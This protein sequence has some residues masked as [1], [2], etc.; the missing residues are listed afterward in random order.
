[1]TIF[2]RANFFTARILTANTQIELNGNTDY[3]VKYNELKI[4]FDQ[5]KSDFNNF[6]SL[7]YGLHTHPYV[8]TPIGPSVTSPTTSM[9]TP[10]TADMSTSKN[11]K[12][13][14]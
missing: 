2:N 4:A 12:V 8:D 6:V 1:M 3:A 14:M 10:S 7:T 5:L 13:T 9:G 11:T